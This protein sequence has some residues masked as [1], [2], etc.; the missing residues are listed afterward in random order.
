MSNPSSC[1]KYV[2]SHACITKKLQLIQLWTWVKA[3]SCSGK[4]FTNLTGFFVAWTVV[5]CSELC[6]SAY[7]ATT[8]PNAPATTDKVRQPSKVS[9]AAAESNPAAEPTLK[10]HKTVA[11]PL[12]RESASG[13]ALTTAKDAGNAGPDAT[14]K[15]NRHNAKAVTPSDAAAG[16]KATKLDHTI[17]QRAR[18]RAPPTLSAAAPPT[19][20]VNP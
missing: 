1:A 3:A 2:G 12:A 10:P 14:P 20:F 16:V 19:P 8:A 13:C 7:R 6:V 4:F 18:T 15:P 17:K 5:V 9:K 11:I